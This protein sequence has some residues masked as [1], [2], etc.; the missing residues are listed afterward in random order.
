MTAETDLIRDIKIKYLDEITRGAN[1]NNICNITAQATGL[2]VA[3]TLATRTLIARSED[4]TEYLIEDYIRG[5]EMCTEEELTRERHLFNEKLYRGKAAVHT[6]PYVHYKRIISGCIWNGSIAAIID[7]P[8]THEIDVEA[9]F[10]VIEEAASVFLL[11]LQLRKYLSSDTFDPV[12]AY[13][14]GILNGE[15]D[16]YFQ[17]Q[18]SSSFALSKD[19][20][21]QLMWIEPEDPSRYLSNRSTILAFCHS[22][23]N[24]WCT[25]H[26]NGIFVLFHSRNQEYP[27]LISEKLPDTEYVTLSDPFENL[28]AIS[29][30]LQ[31]AKYALALARTERINTNLVLVSDYKI[32][33]SLLLHL[34]T[35]ERAD[36]FSGSVMHKIKEYDKAHCTEYYPTL[37]SYLLHNL[38]SRLT[39]NDLNVHRNTVIYRMQRINE[40]FNIDLT[41]CREITA[42][43]LSI[44]ETADLTHNTF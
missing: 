11:A 35:E 5:P 27:H 20:V 19:V 7:C 25:E 18:D 16:N 34:T 10:P 2:P 38:S 21:W 1:L 4:Y 43:Y 41:N 30:Q 40:L 29:Q 14:K 23:E 36:L 24:I 42:L 31:T 26:E 13:L 37:C 22:H 39:A 8:I 32:P 17:Q 44:Y 9:A 33:I 6:F 12:Q 3:L 15:W 28:S